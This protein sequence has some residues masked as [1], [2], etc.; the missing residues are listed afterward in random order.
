MQASWPG[1]NPLGRLR[2]KDD[3]FGLL[4]QLGDQRIGNPFA[5]AIGDSAARRVIAGIDSWR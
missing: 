5:D 4:H 3:G 1:V 2:D